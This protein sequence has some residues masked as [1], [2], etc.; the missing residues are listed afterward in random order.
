MVIK[1]LA[2]ISD[3]HGNYKALE[4]F[5]NYI[6]DKNIDGIL[7]LGDMITDGPNPQKLLG[8]I[9]GMREKY[10]C[11]FIRGNR[12]QYLI[13]NFHT[14]QAFKPNSSAT[15]SLWY[16]ASELK[17]E[18]IRFFESLPGCQRLAWPGCP[19]TLLC[20]GSPTERKCFR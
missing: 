8:M 1:R 2:L 12:E 4:A 18:D 10:P 13:D 16:T 20:H 15:G 14:P 7:C 11:V 17:E 3:I 6:Q 9:R 5:L 19:P